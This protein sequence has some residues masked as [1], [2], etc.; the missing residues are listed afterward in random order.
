MS[1]VREALDVRNGMSVTA[2]EVLDHCQKYFRSF[3]IRNILIDAG[4]ER[5]N[6]QKSPSIIINGRWSPRISKTS[7]VNQEMVEEIAKALEIPG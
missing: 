6:D 4:A 1:N 7:A 3:T 2:L 5:P